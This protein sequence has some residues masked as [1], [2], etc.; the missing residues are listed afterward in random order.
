MGS[1]DAE[2]HPADR[3][4]VGGAVC[5]VAAAGR[6][7]AAV[8]IRGGRIVA[9]GSDRDL[10]GWIGPRTEVIPLRGRMVIPGFQDAHIHPGGGGIDRRRCD[11]SGLTTRAAYRDAIRAYADQHP[12][13]PW[14]LG[15]G[16]A[17]PAFPGGIATAAELDQVV[18]DRPCYLR[19]RD[20]HGAWVNTRALEWAGIDAA[21]PDP[22]DGRIERDAGGRPVGTLQEGA[23]DLVERLVPDVTEAEREIAILEAQGYCHGL[24]I[25]AW[26]D[27]NVDWHGGRYANL[28][29]YRR[30]AERGALTMRV[31]GALWWDRGRGLEQVDEL[32]AARERATHDRFRPTAVKIM[33]DGVLENFTAAVLDPYLDAGGCPSDHRGLS[34][35][36]P[37]VLGAAVPALDRAGFQVH[38]HAIGERAVR[39]SLDAIAAA[40]RVNGMNDLRPHIAHIQVIH[41]DDLDRFRRLGVVAN[42]QP[43][44][45]VNDPQMTELTLPFLGPER[46]SWQ[47]P[48]ASLHRRG[49][50]LAFGSDWPV[51]SCDPLWQLHVAVNRLPPSADVTHQPAHGDTPVFLPAE[52]LDL[53]TAL[54]A[55]TMGSAYVN[56]LDH[57]TGSIEV[58]KAADLVVLD[59]NPFEEPVAA[60]AD[61][62]VAL[63]LVDGR[64]VHTDPALWR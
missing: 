47:Y 63:T 61:A 33:Q 30:L 6:W 49:A 19:S 55:F 10:G 8:A 54:R 16:W 21:T 18:A 62:R 7:A 57:E 64:P 25:T 50:G 4:L 56:H 28:D 36:D 14:I 26:Q 42:A 11:L 32:V 1:T 15:R 39:E 12:E 38:F 37:E 13:L 35:I 29:A 51:S 27:A 17:M 40:R 52:R 31:V 3:I 20:G 43:L 53:P 48:F 23:R 60:I 44:W 2:P 22:A 45:A 5:T 9:V 46:S 59:R 24:G 58:G 34:F 41:P